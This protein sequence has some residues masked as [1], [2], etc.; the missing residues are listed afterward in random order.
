MALTSGTKLGPYEI[1]SPLGAGGMGEVYRARD[2]RLDRTVAVKILPPHLS[3]N[4]EAK[5]RLDREARAISSLNHPNICTLHDIGHQ[6]GTDFLVME[7]LEGETLADRLMKGP[8]PSELVLR[9][10]IEI[11]EGLEKAHK[12]GVIHRDLKPG[13]IMLTKSGAK[14]MDFGL[15]KAT[16]AHEPPPS[17]SLTMTISGPSQPLTAQG[18]VLGTFQYMAP[19]QLEGKEADARSDIFALGAVLYE[20]ASGRRAFTG[21]SQASIVAAILASDPQPIS[22]VQPMS[23]PA[24]DRVVRTCMAKDPDERWQTAHDVKL[25]LQWIAEAGSKAGIPAPV[26]ARRRISQ[27]LAWAVAAAAAVVA[28]AFAIGFVLRAPRPVHPLRVSILP[29]EKHSFDP[30]SIALSPDGAKLA[31]V[32]T[33]AGGAPQLWVRPLDSTAAQPLAGTDD[34]SFPFWSPDSRSLGFFAEGKLKIIEA[35]GGAVQTLA[36]APQP[37][38]GAWGADGTILYTPD[39]ASAMLRIP[40]AG[41]TPS[42]AAGDEKTATAFGSPRWPAFLPDGKHFIFFQFAPDI[43]G[44]GIIHLGALDSQQDTVLGNSDYRALYASGH[45]MFVH[46]GNLMTQSFD[47]KKLK[48]MGNPV[49]IA[50]QVRSEVRGAAAFSLSND[51]KLIFADGQAMSLDL[52]WY[53]RTGKKGDIIDSGTFQ[54]AHIAPDGKKVSAARA[55]AAGHL[56][57]YI[58]DLVRGTKSQFS[59]S[60]SRDDDPVWSPDGNTI[61]F[62]SARSGKIDLYT[63]PANGARQE[64]LLYHDDLDKYVTTW[65]SDGKYIDYETVA[66][67]RIA[68]W[69]MPMFGDRKPFPFVQEKYNARFASFSTDTKWMSFTSF[70]AGHPQVYVVA[71]PKPA[72]RFLVGEGQLAVWSRN[73]K[74]ILYLD[75]HSRIASVE[76]TAHGDSVDLGKPQILFSAQAA[77]FNQFEASADGKRLLMMQPPLQDS[78]SLTLV[79]NWLQ[80]LKNKK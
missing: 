80:E 38:G 40:A 56:E 32:A 39:A 22:A 27:K 57:I 48:L 23:P 53:D 68:I 72:G 18:M 51:G 49:P 52:A 8:L 64:E 7:Y 11:C 54:D 46:G 50:E 9:Y 73:G 31:F 21:K 25:Q 20:M 24:L 4:L 12:N 65:S 79:V 28:V 43:Q 1:Q 36:D 70:E 41:G 69:V 78:P 2:T 77:G 67:N 45:L 3:S 14:L 19:E 59:F 16:P 63:R 37:R 62:D 10:G 33:A 6:D 55:D 30:L 71:F 60:Q 34:A 76:V 29:P 35:S 15:A 61:V 13:N 75:D 44:G 26:A 17:P 42:H 74:E 66:N 58:Y 47:E 5:Q